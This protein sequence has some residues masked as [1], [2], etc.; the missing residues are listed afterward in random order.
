M[1]KI[2]AECA[3]LCSCTSA[4]G[5]SLVCVLLSDAKCHATVQASVHAGAMV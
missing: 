3:S 2:P 4:G 5:T 1:R